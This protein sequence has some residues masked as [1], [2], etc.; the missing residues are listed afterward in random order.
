MELSRQS[1][2][3]A[4]D[5]GR[6]QIQRIYSVGIAVFS[7]FLLSLAFIVGKAFGRHRPTILP[8]DVGL[9]EDIPTRLCEVYYSIGEDVSTKNVQVVQTSLGEPSKQWSEV[10]C[11]HRPRKLAGKSVSPAG[12]VEFAEY[13]HPTAQ[14]N[15]DFNSVAFA[16]REPILGFGGAF[17]E[18]AALNFGSLNTEGQKMVMELLFGRDGLGYRYVTIACVIVNLWC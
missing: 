12:G 18:A 8:Q 7:L 10:A 15:V 14:I 6:D 13:G 17:T 3:N 5:N 4:S 9:Q 2:T 11:I 1:S 16:G